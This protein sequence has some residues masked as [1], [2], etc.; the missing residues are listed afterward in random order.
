MFLFD[1]MGI[2][3]GDYNNDGYPDIVVNNEVGYNLTLWHN[4]SL[5]QH[6]QISLGNKR[7]CHGYSKALGF[8]C[9]H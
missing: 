8:A 1:D 9:R 6:P 7:H 2:T 3:I 5:W 4:Q